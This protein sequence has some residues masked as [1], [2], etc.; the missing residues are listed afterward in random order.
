MTDFKFANTVIAAIESSRFGLANQAAADG[1]AHGALNG[2]TAADDLLAYLQQVLAKVPSADNESHAELTALIK[3]T[4]KDV[5]AEAEAEHIKSSRRERRIFFWRMMGLI[6]VFWLGVL[7]LVLYHLPT[8]R[9][10]IS[11]NG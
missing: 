11:L 3:Q 10:L 2:E 9:W 7:A 4:V 5:A 6:A 1:D 8:I